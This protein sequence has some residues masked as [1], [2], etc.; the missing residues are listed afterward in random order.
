MVDSYCVDER[1]L[2]FSVSIICYS[3]YLFWICY[4]VL[5]WGAALTHVNPVNYVGLIVSIAFI[6]LNTKLGKIISSKKLK[7]PEKQKPQKKLVLKAK[8]IQKVKQV[9]KLHDRQRT[10]PIE[11][12]KQIQ[13]VEKEEKQ[14][15]QDSEV[16][17]RCAH[18]LGYLH[19]RP[20]SSE[21]PEE[22]LDC[23]YVV[24]CLSPTAQTIE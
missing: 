8:K 9:P 5:V 17:P 23:D 10:Q 4:D 14:M 2:W 15:T 11:Q 19:K 13:P 3:W 18:Y 24:N 22:C 16:P 12:V 20:N 21:I 1:I 6:G 7:F